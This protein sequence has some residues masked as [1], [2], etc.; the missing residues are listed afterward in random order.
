M[1]NT[2]LVFHYRQLTESFS[3]N[4]QFINWGK[5]ELFSHVGHQS[6]ENG[7]LCY[8]GERMFSIIGY[9]VTEVNTLLHQPCKFLIL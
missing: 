3:D 9:W 7:H 5:P 1:L 8:L 6:T 4:N 2:Q